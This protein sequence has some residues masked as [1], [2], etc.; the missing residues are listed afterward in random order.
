MGREAFFWQIVDGRLPRPGCT[1][2]L[3][4]AF[5]GIR[6]DEPPP[7]TGEIFQG[8]ELIAAATAAAITRQGSLA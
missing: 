5:G 8:G 2:T 7:I 3:G 1:R 6:A 4:I